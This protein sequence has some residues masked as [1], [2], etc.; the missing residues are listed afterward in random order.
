MEKQ[1]K[2]YSYLLYSAL[3]LIIF[4]V[5]FLLY[6]SWLIN[7]VPRGE[8]RPVDLG[9]L[10]Q[11][12]SAVLYYYREYG[13]IPPE[14][15]MKRLLLERNIVADQTIFYSAP[16]GIEIRYFTSVKGFVLVAPGHNG[17]YDTPKGYEQILAS[18]DI[19]DD[20]VRFDEVLKDPRIKRVDR[21]GPLYNPRGIK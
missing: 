21:D 11:L 16:S 20:Y 1:S 17:Q 10:R 19:G 9:K 13:E 2:R 12:H 8:A 3:G 4:V 6:T 15:E 18:K 14:G 7:R 5:S